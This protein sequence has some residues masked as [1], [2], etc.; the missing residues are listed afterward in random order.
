M[1]FTV[2][3]SEVPL[4]L[5]PIL[6]GFAS[7][8]RKGAMQVRWERL[9]PSDADV[10]PYNMLEVV[11]EDGKRL[12][13]DMNDGYE[14]LLQEKADMVPF[15]NGL[16]DRCDLFFKRSFDGQRNALL[17]APEKMRR[18]PPNFLVT[19]PHNPA[20][21][22][23]PCDPNREKIKKLIRML[24]GSQYY[25][26]HILEK[27]IFDTPRLSEKPRILFMARL[28]DPAGDFPGQLTPA[29]Q[30][31]RYAINESR[32]SCIRLLR[33]AFGENF[34]GGVAPSAFS[35][36]EYADVVLENEGLS[37]KNAYL[38]FMKQFDIHIATMG[39]HGST[40]WKFAEYLAASKAVVCEPLCYESA[41]GLADGTHYLSFADGDACVRQVQTLM[42]G[43]RRLAMMQANHAYAEQYMRCEAFVRYALRECGYTLQK[44]N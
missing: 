10:L 29:M 18:T 30:Q 36:K 33:D 12:I 43:D 3:L 5:Y 32:A 13:F 35:Q 34:C 1:T 39:L 15:Y 31:E 23:V 24:P 4:H 19:L 17:C 22:P 21:F 7:L 2:R 27:N 37:H 26:G 11:G 28:W 6:A 42:D 9:H 14:N 40:G 41:G 25:N 16:L 44:E 8:R 20:H 38:A